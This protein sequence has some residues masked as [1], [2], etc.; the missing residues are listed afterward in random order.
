MSFM[1][2]TILVYY[3]EHLLTSS[4][5]VNPTLEEVSYHIGIIEGLYGFCAFLGGMIWGLISDRI[6]RKNSLILILSGV[7]I[8]SIGFGLAPNFEVALFWR[9]MGGFCA[10]IIPTT[11]TL[12]RDLSDDSN[13]SILYSYFGAGYGAASIFGPFL[14]GFLSR[15]NTFLPSYLTCA[16]LEDYPYFIPLLMQ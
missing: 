5:E 10:G 6:G 7:G 1:L 4:G 16:F 9:I 14:G 3:L 12:M 2:P 15:P 13:I 8:T 11:K